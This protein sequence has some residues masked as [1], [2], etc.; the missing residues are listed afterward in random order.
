MG[1]GGYKL[2]NGL[3]FNLELWADQFWISY[4]STPHPM[5][6]GL[7]IFQSEI[8]LHTGEGGARQ[9]SSAIWDSS[10]DLVP[11]QVSCCYNGHDL[12]HNNGRRMKHKKYLRKQVDGEDSENISDDKEDEESNISLSYIKKEDLSQRN[13]EG[14]MPSFQKH[15]GESL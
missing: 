1:G 15:L 3:D 7:Q 8:S 9:C 5:V 11:K 12:Q 14:L 4:I 6:F 13:E 2:K 10:E